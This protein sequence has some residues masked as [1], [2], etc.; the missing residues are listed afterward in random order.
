MKKK[1]IQNYFKLGILFLGISLLMTN[2]DEDVLVPQPEFK[3]EI[4]A[5]KKN[6]I[7]QEIETGFNKET[8]SNLIPYSFEIDW[9]E[10]EKKFS[11]ELETDYY[12]F[13]LIYLDAFNPNNINKNKGKGQYFI[14]YKILVIQDT[15]T[16]FSYYLLKFHQRV[17]L[18]DKNQIL[19][20]V[21]LSNNNF[22]GIVHAYDKDEDLV[23]A[24]RLKNGKVKDNKFLIKKGLKKNKTF[25]TQKSVPNCY[26]APT[27]HYKD[28]WRITNDSDG[29][30][31]EYI[32]TEL[33]GVTYEQVCDSEWY[34]D[35]YTGGG[36]G[37]GT[38]VGSGVGNIYEDC[39]NP[40]PCLH[41][42]ID[43]ITDEIIDDS[44]IT[45]QTVNPCVKNIIKLL[46]VKDN[47]YSVVPS[48]TDQPV[49]HISQ[50][51][52]DLFDSSTKYNLNFSIEQLGTDANGNEKNGETTKLA[53]DFTS[54]S[55]KIDSD[56]ANNGTQLFIAKTLIHESIHAIMGY[57]LKEYRTSDLASQLGKLYNKYK[58]EGNTDKVAN[59][60]T[61]HEFMSGYVEAFAYSLAAWDNHQQ[62]MDYYKMLSWGGLE[63]SQAYKDLDNKTE[64]QKVIQN[65]R[66]NKNDAKGFKCD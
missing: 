48:I 8:F 55:I 3:Q 42:I 11:N 7:T 45:D 64:I 61:E 46:S 51:V 40:Y 6:S 58:D 28:W 1:Q 18:S 19:S 21:S 62:S 32:R 54:W 66:Y 12:E 14:K 65:E 43:A 31:I 37:G 34:P 53:P 33:L 59:N 22:D 5:K 20:D 9:S 30:H 63:A 15:E 47:H 27:Y 35:L 52:L 29:I 49:S 50:A 4:I 25:Y 56:L 13:S 2:C 60:L 26:D 44:I 41:E 23:F 39:D 16:S 24:K 38:Y 57:S 10:P 36:G 17:K